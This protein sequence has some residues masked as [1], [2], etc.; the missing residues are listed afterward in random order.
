MSREFL[1]QSCINPYVSDEAVRNI[2]RQGQGKNRNLLLTGP[3]NHGKNYILNPLTKVYETFQ[4]RFQVTS[5]LLL[6]WKVK[7]ECF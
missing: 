5:M 4:N 6:V 1:K 2:L 3:A 7:R